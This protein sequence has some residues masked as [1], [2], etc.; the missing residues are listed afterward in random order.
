M[1]KKSEFIQ[2]YV[3][4]TLNSTIEIYNVTVKLY[5]ER[6]S[7]EDVENELMLKNGKVPGADDI[8]S[9]C[10][11]NIREQLIKQ[12]HNLI[13]KIKNQEEIPIARR[14]S[15]IVLCPVFQYCWW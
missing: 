1:T 3:S 10:L 14:I 12:V 2:E 13:C 6:P 15:I 7:I 11:K 4:D 8:I 9:E 5:I